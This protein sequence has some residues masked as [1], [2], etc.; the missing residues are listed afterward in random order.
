MATTV[1]T[2]R[3]LRVEEAYL[4]LRPPQCCQ[5]GISEQVVRWLGRMPA[6]LQRWQRLFLLVCHHGDHLDPGMEAVL[7]YGKSLILH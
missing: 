4:C 7:P 6:E 2:P 1:R 5:S 3:P